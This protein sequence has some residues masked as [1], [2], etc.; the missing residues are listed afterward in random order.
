MHNSD[1]SAL[2]RSRVLINTHQPQ[3]DFVFNPLEHAGTLE[4]IMTIDSILHTIYVSTDL[5]KEIVSV[6]LYIYIYIYIYKVPNG[7]DEGYEGD[8][9][10]MRSLI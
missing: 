6:S 4:Q 2:K 10:Q 8:S 7:F 3:V 5:F 9:R 1:H